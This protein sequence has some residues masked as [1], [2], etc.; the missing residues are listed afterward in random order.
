MRAYPYPTAAHRADKEGHGCLELAVDE[1]R[2]IQRSVYA[3][4]HLKVP[5]AVAVVP[6]RGGQGVQGA[7]IKRRK[8]R[9]ARGTGGGRGN[10]SLWA[11]I[12]MAHRPPTHCLAAPISARFG[13]SA[14]AGVLCIK[15]Q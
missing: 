9:S 3:A 6:K 13:S 4:R 5:L 7:A 11:I 8:G 12:I 15:T 1:A 14:N 10:P 2:G